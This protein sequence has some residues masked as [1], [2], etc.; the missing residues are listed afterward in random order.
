MTH[1]L[2]AALVATRRK[3]SVNLRNPRNL[4]LKNGVNLLDA[5]SRS[6][7]SIIFLCANSNF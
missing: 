3:I 4:R 5:I 6:A 1:V 7:L 2:I